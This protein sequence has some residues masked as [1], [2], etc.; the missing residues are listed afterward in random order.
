M[1]AARAIRC[2]AAACLVCAGCAQVLGFDQ[3]MP[4]SDGQI[5]Q[6][7]DDVQGCLSGACVDSVCVA[8]D[9]GPSEASGAEAEAGAEAGSSSPRVLVSGQSNP[10]GIA[11]DGE[12][13]F[14]A[15]TGSSTIMQCTAPDCADAGP[16]VSGTS[17]AP[18]TVVAVKGSVFWVTGSALWGVSESGGLAVQ[19]AAAASPAFLGTDGT[20]VYFETDGNVSWCPASL[21]A[22]TPTAVFPQPLSAVEGLSLANGLVYV[23]AGQ[24]VLSCPFVGCTQPTTLAS[25][26]FGISGLAVSAAGIFIGDNGGQILGCP[27]AGSCTVSEEVL[28]ANQSSPSSLLLDGTNLYWLAPFPAAAGSVSRC[29]TASCHP[30]VL[31]SGQSAPAAMVVDDEYLYFTVTGEGAVKRVVK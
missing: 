25:G 14:W 4:L 18:V 8:T 29:D 12:K 21:Q 9:A 26:L 17:G 2:G 19:L 16:L 5:G 15:D 3:R 30:T 11:I 7:C 31:A 1:S 22:C 20:Q 23:A 10:A 6:P 13:L 28:A 24:Q 27:L